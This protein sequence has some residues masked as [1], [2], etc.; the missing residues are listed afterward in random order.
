MFD[1]E[2]IKNQKIIIVGDVM[3]DAYIFGN[4]DRISPEAPVPVVAQ[5]SQ[6]FRLGGAANVALNIKAMGA[7]PLLFGVAGNDDDAKILKAELEKNKIASN[8]IIEE[9]QRPTTVKT[10]IIGNNHQLLRVDKEVTSSILSATENELIALLK[11]HIKDAKALIF[12]DY[13]K[14]LLQESFIQAITQLCIAHDVPVIVDPKKNN[15]MAYSHATLFKPNLKEIREGLKLNRLDTLEEIEAAARQLIQQMH[16]KYVMVTLSDRGVMICD[17]QHT[18]HIPAHIRKIADVSGAGDTVVSI[19]ALCMAQQLAP[20][21]IAAL[22]NLAG[23]LV[24]EEV[25]V[26][27]LNKE[28]FFAEIKRLGLE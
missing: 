19:A 16:L 22:S 6:E 14:G 13:E 25:G 12:E 18:H 9:G 28:H 23:G 15:F 17:A 1:I 24:C 11:L 26:V 3:L 21:S 20:A 27:P 10:R 5:R 7:T 4:V 2:K 8:F